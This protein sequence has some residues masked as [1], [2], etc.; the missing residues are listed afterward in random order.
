MKDRRFRFSVFL[1]VSVCFLIATACNWVYNLTQRGGT[2]T[3]IATVPLALAVFLIRFGYDRFYRQGFYTK[4]QALAFYLKCQAVSPSGIV[5][6]KEKQFTEI[7]RDVISDVP[8]RKGLDTM[9]HYKI[10]Y[11]E[12]KKQNRR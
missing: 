7:Y 12:G 1:V 6:S 3:L 2:A 10:I 9:N 4:K 5:A 8:L 11:N